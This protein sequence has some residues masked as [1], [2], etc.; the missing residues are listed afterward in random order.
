MKINYYMPTRVIAGENCVFEN[1]AVLKDLGRRALIVTG[2]HSARAN[3]SY[4]DVVKALE[5]NGQ[6]YALYD[7]VV[8]NPTVDN[9][10]EAAALAR[11]EQCGFIVAIGGGSPL[12]AAKVAA[13]L[14]LREVEKAEIF[15]TVFT[16]ALP[17]AAVPTTAGTGSEVSP[18]AVLTNDAEQTKTSISF[19]ALFARFAF[20]DARY[21]ETLPRQVTI[22]TAIDALSHAIE[23][24]LSIRASAPSDMLARESI[25]L[26][27]ECF[28]DLGGEQ[29]G[30]P[31]RWKLLYASTLAGMVIA[32]AGTTA[33]H[34]LGYMLTY[35]KHL[36]HGRANG[37][38]LAQ[39][40][41]FVEEAERSPK[42]GPS[43]R[44]GEI[45]GALQLGSVGEFARILDR[46]LGEKEK[47]EDL[48]L[49]YYADR[50]ITTKNIQNCALKPD[51]DD[52]LRILRG[53][54]A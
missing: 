11:R 43:G 4:A 7:Q 38:L 35:F 29:A 15:G 26:I 50:S 27:A 18:A 45:L 16:G 28:E 31:V 30:L 23:G 12:D 47:P 14:A 41:R 8:S 17:I 22:N 32:N 40:L 19:P 10:Y 49:E 33:V 51:R 46:L 39:Y 1:R 6:T 37:L 53:S 25:R 34:A 54:F 42:A 2:K 52:L 13:A 20:L 5:A 48:E 24:M 9:A 36:D 21:T 44:I 3:G